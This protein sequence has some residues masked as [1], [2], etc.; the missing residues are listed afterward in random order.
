MPDQSDTP[1][2][3]YIAY[4]DE[5][6]DPGLERVKGIDANG[7]S[8]LAWSPEVRPGLSFESG[9][10]QSLE[11]RRGHGTEGTIDRGDHLGAA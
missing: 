10:F 11:R 2:Y 9:Y 3:E 6:G 8:E 5:S 4:V 1:E 7:A